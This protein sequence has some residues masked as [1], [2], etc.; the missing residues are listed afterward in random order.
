MRLLVKIGRNLLGGVLILAGVVMLFTPG[1]GILTIL[2]GFAI[3][4]FPG[5]E[6]IASWVRRTRLAE[7]IRRHVQRRRNGTMKEKIELREGDITKMDVEA[8]VNAA[9]NDLL[10]GAGVAGAIRKAGGPSIQEECNKIGRIPIGE[11]AITGAGAMKARHVIHAASMELGGMTTAESLRASTKNSLLRA[12]EKGLKTVAFPAIGTGIAG[13]PLDECA[14]IMLDVVAEHLRGKTSI[15]K[16]Y[17]VL[18]GQEAF[19][20]FRRQYDSMFR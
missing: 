11:A 9:N 13:F 14:R 17:F 16:V 2:L 1:Q 6:R 4:D 19:Q 18:F 5:K 3:M 10:L 7:A 12:D 15:E 20:A 8:V